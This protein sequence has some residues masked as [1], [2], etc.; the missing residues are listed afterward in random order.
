M[1]RSLDLA[2]LQRM[3]DE[4]YISVQQ[5][6]RLDLYIYNYTQSAQYDGVWNNETLQCRGLIMDSANTIIAR[7][8]PKFFNLQEAIDKGEQLPAEEF[9]VTEKMDGSL[10]ILYWDGDKP[11][12]A[13]R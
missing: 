9:V 11:A 13:T 10:G 12:L 6:P 5:H 1:V 4:R 2:N 3:I 7:P 8:F